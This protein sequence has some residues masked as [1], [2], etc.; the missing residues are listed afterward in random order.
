M[1]TN[2]KH[3]VQKIALKYFETRRGETKQLVWTIEGS[4]PGV[5]PLRLPSSQANH[6]LVQIP[7]G[8]TLVDLISI[9]YAQKHRYGLVER[10][11]QGMVQKRTEASSINPNR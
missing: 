6:L 8:R 3:Q 10:I 2:N 1:N 4:S 5:L 11:A 9:G 7:C